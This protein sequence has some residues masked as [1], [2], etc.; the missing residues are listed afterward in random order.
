MS[1]ELSNSKP[2]GGI[3]GDGM[4]VGKTVETLAA[5][6]ANKAD[7]ADVKANRKATLVVAPASAITQW[8]NEIKS[9]VSK[10]HQHIAAS[11]TGSR[12]IKESSRRSYSTE[13]ANPICRESKKPI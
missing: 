4:G 6:V 13:T 8:S 5:M 1:R 11:L 3:L 12:W 9:H 2:H 7:Q 10:V